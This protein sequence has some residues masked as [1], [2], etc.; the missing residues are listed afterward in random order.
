MTRRRTRNRQLYLHVRLTVGALVALPLALLGPACSAGR[1]GEANDLGSGAAPS[2]TGGAGGT[3]IG[4]T[5]GT[6]GT[7][8]VDA[9][10]QP[11]IDASTSMDAGTCVTACE[12]VGGRYCGTIGNDCGGTLDCG[13][14]DGDWTCESGICVGGPSCTPL[15][16]AQ[17]TTSLCGVVGDGCGRSLDCGACAGGDVCTGGLCIPPGCV[18][19]T[20][21]VAG[22]SFCGT[23][24][25]GCGGILECGECDG[26]ATCGGGG[27]ESVCGGD[28]S[29]VKV[30][31]APTTGG[32]YCGVIGDGCG[33]VVDCGECPDLAAC[34]STGFPNVC[35]GSETTVCTGLACAVDA[36]AGGGTTSVSGTVYDPAGQN[37]L[38]NVIV[39]VPNLEPGEALPAVPEGASCDRCDAVQLGRPITTALTDT[40][41]NFRLEGVPTGAN[42][43]LV[44]Q[45]GKWRRQVTIPS[46][47]SCT[48]TPLTDKNLTRLPR[49]QAE[50]HLP[51]IAITTGGSDALECLV[52]KIGVADAE[53]TTQTGGGRVHLFAGYEA[54][55][56]MANGTALPDANDLWEDA[57]LLN[58]YDVMVMSC[59]GSDNV[60]RSTEAYQ[61][62]RG[63]ADVGGRIFG[64][65]WHN[66]WIHPEN[67]P[68]PTVVKFASGAH[69]F[70]DPITAQ[71]D[72]SFPKG[73][74]FSEWLV[75]VG[76]TPTPG[77]I[78]IQGAEHSVDSVTAGVAQRWIYGD[79]AEKNT[80][81]VQYFSFNTPIGGAECGRMVFSDLHVSAGMGTDSGKVPFPTGCT[82]TTLTPQEKALEFMLFDLSSCVQSDMDPVTPPPPVPGTP[83]PPTGRPPAPPVP[84]PPPPPPPVK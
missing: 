59:E 29:C 56:T 19:L 38:Y 21:D 51:K 75:N 73:M 11:T 26:A 67:E 12:Q 83:P 33:G 65:H 15:G 6:G 24:G 60:S 27:L 76:A 35:P 16:C 70:D 44:M 34:G 47:A 8:T 37:P 31:C 39:Y 48:D 52:R 41:G 25:D 84:P 14:C 62:V 43:P 40:H 45:I 79:D 82:T 54:P 7:L 10:N 77:Q 49:S 36:C 72:V 13:T 5:G 78:T 23:I 58:G 64:S 81:M 71:I 30:A 74:A 9:G 80:P 32:N 61:N 22:G 57:A 55:T 63:Y 50:G 17:D 46:V 53:F 28:P 68:Y 18:P 69:G 42:I 3:G 4:A 20:C 2:G 1:A 66:G